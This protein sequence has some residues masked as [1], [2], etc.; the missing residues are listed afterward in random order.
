MKIKVNSVL[1][2][3]LLASFSIQAQ[4]EDDDKLKPHHIVVSMVNTHMPAFSSDGG[5]THLLIPT[6]G[7]SYE[8]MFNKHIAIEWANEIEIANYVLETE[9]GEKIDRET[10]IS[11]SLLFVYNPIEGLGFAAGPG[12]E[13]EKSE[14]YFLLLF[15][16]TYEWELPKYFDISPEIS[17][18]LKDGQVNA[19]SFGI[20]IGYRMGKD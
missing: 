10:P 11:T 3:L 13:F 2:I 1:L 20:R 4:H 12:M 8:Y 9:D 6:W 5:K 14:D 17:Y 19:F 16:I 18:K 15:A 7:L